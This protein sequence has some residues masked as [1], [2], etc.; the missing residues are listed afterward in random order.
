MPPPPPKKIRPFTPRTITA[1]VVFGQPQAKCRHHGICRIDDVQL[2]TRNFCHGDRVKGILRWQQPDTCTLTVPTFQLPA[3]KEQ[4]HLGGGTIRLHRPQPLNKLF[5]SCTNQ[6][7][8]AGKYE[9]FQLPEA[10]E[11]LILVAANSGAV[12][13]AMK[14]VQAVT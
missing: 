12:A 7:L 11:I 5:P 9:I 6:H 2:I 14:V 1:D 8:V 4:L 10:Y 3:A 13:G